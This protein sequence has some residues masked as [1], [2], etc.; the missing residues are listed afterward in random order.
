VTT[1]AQ[2]VAV[3]T[4]VKAHTVRGFTDAHREVQKPPLLSGISRSYQPL[5]ED[6]ETLPSE[7]TRV[8]VSATE[9]LADVQRTLT[10]LFDVVLTQDTA[11]TH[12]TADVV[13]DGLTLLRKVPV[14]YLMFLEKRLVD[15][16]T[17]VDKLPVLDPAEEWEFDTARGCYASTPVQTVRSKKIPRNHV[18]Y[19]ATDKHPAQVD[20][21]ME[22]VPVGRWTTTK[23]SGALPATRIKELRERVVK[24]QQA[25]KYAREQ[26]NN[27]EVTDVKAGDL[28][29]GYLFA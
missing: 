12:A 13:V 5:D 14:T 18:K 16:Y 1:L 29:F 25:V 11:N 20:V 15:L 4:G 27:T 19:E 10:R 7:S 22:D 3:T 2:L 24:L 21:W 17:F 6:G 23:L 9:V 8:Q 28:V 26:A